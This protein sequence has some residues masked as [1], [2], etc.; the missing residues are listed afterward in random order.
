[1]CKVKFWSM[2][3]NKYV[4]KSFETFAE[5]QAFAVRYN[6]VIRCG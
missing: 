3:L 5:A 4:I 2:L 1:M 6:G